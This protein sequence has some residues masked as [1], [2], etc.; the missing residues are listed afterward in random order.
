MKLQLDHL[1]DDWM[2]DWLREREATVMNV[3][4]SNSVHRVQVIHARRG[5]IEYEEVTD[6]GEA[7]LYHHEPLAILAGGLT[8]IGK[9]RDMAHRIRDDETLAVVRGLETPDIP[10]LYQEYMDE[11]WQ[12]ENHRSVYGPSVRRQR[13]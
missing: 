13:N 5:D 6:L 4:G 2:A 3:D 12:V 10:R 1:P 8:M 11:L 7:A 9:V